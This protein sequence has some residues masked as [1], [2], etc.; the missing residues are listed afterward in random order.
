[1]G[2]TQNNITTLGAL[3]T[4]STGANTTAGTIIGNWSLS[5]GSQLRATYADLAE[6]Y[7]A[8]EKI[9]PGTVVEFG[10]EHEVQICNS[11]MSTL[12]A[13]IVTTN[14]AYLMNS[15]MDCLYPVAVALQGLQVDNRTYEMTWM[16]IML[17]FV[18]NSPGYLPGYC[19]GNIDKFL[20]NI[21]E[22]EDL[23]Y[24]FQEWESW[25]NSFRV[26]GPN[27]T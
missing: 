26:S 1:M 11:Y 8:S 10:G 24:Y 4:L 17:Q 21:Y 18:T 5:A 25:R 23:L 22:Y 3:T 16:S 19:N 2:A 9:E 7:A 27:R 15:E 14:P 6:Y 13:G 20:E 12:V